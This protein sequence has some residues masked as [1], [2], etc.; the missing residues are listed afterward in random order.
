MDDT[1]VE[2]FIRYFKGEA[3]SRQL[4]SKFNKMT[5]D[6][7]RVSEDLEQHA[8]KVMAVFDE[9]VQNIEDVDET[10]RILG[11]ATGPHKH[12]IGFHSGMYLD[13]LQP[14]LEAMKI[15]L[16]DRYTDNMDRIYKITI[17]YFLDTIIKSHQLGS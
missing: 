14:F 1:G 16:G 3:T 15:T 8:G 5:A 4:F 7:L 9:C 17:R 10:A 11:R 2:M 12:L 6:Q 13:F